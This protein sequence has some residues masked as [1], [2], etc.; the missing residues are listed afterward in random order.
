MNVFLH[1]H[2]FKMWI[3]R[4]V[5]FNYVNFVIHIKEKKKEEPKPK[6]LMLH[7][8]TY[9]IFF[10]HVG[11]P[12]RGQVSYRSGIYKKLHKNYNNSKGNRIYWSLLMW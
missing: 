2:D 10:N 3:Q 5:S 1:I 12:Q 8:K 6:S 4:H 9:N 7:G 11:Y